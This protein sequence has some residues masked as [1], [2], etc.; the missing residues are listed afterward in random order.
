MP[1]R[2][3][4]KQSFVEFFRDLPDPRLDRRKRHDLVEMLVITLCA[5]LTG[6]ESWIEIE[7]FGKVRL[8]WLRT[9]L[10]LE[11]GIPSHDTFGRVF[12]LLDPEEFGRRFLD[13]IQSVCLK[14]KGRIIAIDGKTLRRSYDRADH[15]AA[16]HMIS[17]WAVECRLVLGQLRTE[18]KSNEITA[19]PELL[20][21][22][23]VKGCIVTIDAMG[24][25]KAI[26]QQITKAGGEYVLGLKGNQTQLRDEV[27][28]FFRC[29]ERDDYAHLDH[30]RHETVEKDHGR[31]ER[32]EYRIVAEASFEACGEWG[33]LRAVGMVQSE[34]TTA[35]GTSRETRYYI[36]SRMM[37]AQAFAAAVRGHW[38][39][40][41]GLHWAL[42]VVFREDDSRVRKD[43]APE[44]LSIVRRLAL[45]LLRE[46]KTICKYGLKAKRHR[47][48]ID[49]SYLIEVLGV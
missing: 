7:Q 34:R 49:N 38:G 5:V 18:A 6:A 36:C 29:A 22:L 47:C 45:N 26:A 25:Q 46:E 13:W 10:K 12:R 17:A 21:L 4:P 43:H 33:G 1:T 39:V 32:R 20:R 24:C 9:F 27:D 14:G 42:D 48:A 23:D 35:E 2:R 15:K 30:D 3:A 31:V 16:V 37:S 28:H 40:E 41:N 19:I 11:N 44:N 8:D